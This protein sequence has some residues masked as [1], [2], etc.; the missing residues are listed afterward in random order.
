MRLEVL[1]GGGAMPS[2]R[3]E[4]PFEAPAGDALDLGM[5]HCRL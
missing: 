3:A 2:S 5:L 1:W 4:M